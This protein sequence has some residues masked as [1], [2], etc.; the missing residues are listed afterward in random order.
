VGLFLLRDT[1]EAHGFPVPLASFLK[2][3]SRV[4]RIPPNIPDDRETLLMKRQDG[5]RNIPVS[6]EA[7]HAISHNPKLF[8]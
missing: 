6:T 7:R 3:A 2:G 8:T 5:K 4:H 1:S